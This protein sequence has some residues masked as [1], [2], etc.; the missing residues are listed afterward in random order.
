MNK[1]IIY[2]DE[3]SEKYNSFHNRSN[4][5]NWLQLQKIKCY[6]NCH[7][8]NTIIDAGCGSGRL[9]LP[10]AGELKTYKKL[11]GIEYSESM[12]NELYKNTNNC[13]DTYRIELY[14]LS[15]QEYLKRNAEVVDLVYFSYSLHQIEEDKNKQI[16]ILKST[17]DV[18]SA[19]KV[20][21]ITASDE[22]FDKSLLNLCSKK[23]N[24][25]DRSRFLQFDELRNE[26][27]KISIYENEMNYF[28][29]DYDYICY[30]IDQKFISSLQILDDD[31]LNELKVNLKA[32]SH[33]NI[34]NWTDY[35]TYITLEI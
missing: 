1:K 32:Y 24:E 18:L 7:L 33:N 13:L 2:W 14:N 26:N 29:I 34:L 6:L 12:Y 31:E 17:F 10:L 23:L 20:L 21:L 4:E 30:L 27:F 11:I 28:P 19:K 25:F 3:L 5:L 9:L 22:L 8:Y 15:Y 35:Y 16:E